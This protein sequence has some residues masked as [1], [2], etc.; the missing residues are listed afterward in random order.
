MI[1]LKIYYKKKRGFK[2]NLVASITLKRWNNVTNTYNI[3]TI[4]IKTKAITVI[5]QRFNLNNA[6][7]ELNHRLDI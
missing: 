5:N 2:Y 3:E 6:Y 1:Y 4:H 7:E